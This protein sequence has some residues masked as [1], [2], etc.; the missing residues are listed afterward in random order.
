[1]NGFAHLDRGKSRGEPALTVGV[2]RAL[3]EDVPRA[4][5]VF[6]DDATAYRIGAYAPVYVNAGPPA[7]VADTAD[8]FPYKRRA[9]ARRFFRTGNL[10]IV[11]HY[12]AHWVVVDEER[13]PKF[14]LALPR[15]YHDE[16][17]SLYRF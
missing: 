8:N 4:D 5:I 2:I 12:G 11:R 15:V 9:D 10:A 7:H 14:T 3:R 16:R 6:S 13:Y 1:V 17:Y